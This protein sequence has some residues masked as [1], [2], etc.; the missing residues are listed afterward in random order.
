MS[1]TFRKITPE[2][3]D[4]IS[5]RFGSDLILKTKQW[6]QA[7]YP[8]EACK[9]F[10]KVNCEYNDCYY[11]INPNVIVLDAQFNELVPIKKHTS[12]E[13]IFPTING[14]SEVKEMIND[15]SFFMDSPIPELYVKD[16]N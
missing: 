14:D 10:V 2:E 5:K 9:V 13:D 6:V 7:F 4:E 15:F 16:N 11:D 1:T 3:F 12:I 8:R